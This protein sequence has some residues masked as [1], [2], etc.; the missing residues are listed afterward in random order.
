MKS[1][2]RMPGSKICIFDPHLY[3]GMKGIKFGG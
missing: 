2:C 3:L 1:W